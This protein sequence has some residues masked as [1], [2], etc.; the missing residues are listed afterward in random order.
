MTSDDRLWLDIQ[1]F[2]HEGKTPEVDHDFMEAIECVLLRLI[3]AEGDS[4]RLDR[5]EERGWTIK[6]DD[7]ADKEYRRWLVMP[8]V[9]YGS[10]LREAIDLA[11][12]AKG[13]E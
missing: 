6:H 7:D 1:Q 9:I 3:V 5:V 4:D 2:R 10:T 13:G 8:D 11:T 12:G